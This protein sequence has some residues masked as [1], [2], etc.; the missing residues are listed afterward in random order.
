MIAKLTLVGNLGN[1]AE[2]VHRNGKNILNLSVA[3]NRQFKNGEKW[4]TK[5]DWFNVSKVIPDNQLEAYKKNIVN[6]HKGR[7]VF[8]EGTMNAKAY[9]TKSGSP[10]VD[11]QVYA[12]IIKGLDKPKSSDSISESSAAPQGAP[13]TAP[14]GGANALDDL[15]F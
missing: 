7:Q 12:D 14:E 10:A 1:N 5:T 13:E 3:H 11:V 4:D 8:V 6:L 9:Q 15:P 2:I